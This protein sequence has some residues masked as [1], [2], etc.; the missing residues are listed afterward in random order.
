MPNCSFLFKMP[1]SEWVPDQ[2]DD[3]L[4]IREWACVLFKFQVTLM[5]PDNIQSSLVMEQ[6]VSEQ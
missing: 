3:N 6:E 2:M 5:C 1:L 4:R